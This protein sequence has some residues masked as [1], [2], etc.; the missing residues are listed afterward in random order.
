MTKILGQMLVDAASVEDEKVEV[1]IKSAN[2]ISDLAS[3][4][5]RAGAQTEMY[6][7]KRD[8]FGENTFVQQIVA[9]W[10][11]NIFYGPLLGS[12]W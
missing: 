2:V 4:F 11:R 6:E 9:T 10:L 8:A 1:A 3:T 12:N 7:E 5:T